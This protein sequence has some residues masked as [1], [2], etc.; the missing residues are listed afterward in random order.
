MFY[1]SVIIP[2]YNAAQYITGCVDSILNQTLENVEVIVVNDCSTDNSMEVCRAKYGDNPRVQLIDQEKNGGPAA[3]RNRGIE[4]ARGEYIAF[5]DSDDAMLPD[6]LKSMYTT[7]KLMNADVL[8]AMG[9]VYPIIEDMPDDL[10]ELTEDQMLKVRA[11]V[12]SP[13]DK[14]TL[15]DNDFG[16][17]LDNW[18]G[19]HYMW[20]IWNKL[21]KK[22]FLKEKNLSFNHMRLAEDQIFCFGAMFKADRYVV[23]PGSWYIYRLSNESLSRGKRNMSMLERGLRSQFQA[24]KA[25]ENELKDIP[26]F[27]EHKEDGE[28][29]IDFILDGLESSFVS[30]CYKAVGRDAVLHDESINKIFEEYYGD[31]ADFAKYLFCQDHDRFMDCDDDRDKYT[32]I[33]FWAQQK[34]VVNKKYKP[35]H[36]YVKSDDFKRVEPYDAGIYLERYERVRRNHPCF[37]FEL[38]ENVNE[39][40][41][42]KSVE[43]V[44]E[45]FPWMRYAAVVDLDWTYY[46][47]NEKVFLAEDDLPIVI[48][49]GSAPVRPGY[50][51]ANFH[52]FAIAYD[53]NYIMFTFSHTIADGKGMLSFSEAVMYRYLS[54]LYGD[55]E[56]PNVAKGKEGNGPVFNYKNIAFDYSLIDTSYSFDDFTKPALKIQKSDDEFIETGEYAEVKTDAEAFVKFAKEKGT[57]PAI[58]AYLLL[59]EMFQRLFHD[60]EKHVSA[61]MMVDTRKLFDA[62]FSMKNCVYEARIG[63]PG[64][65]LGKD[66]FTENAQEARAMM[67]A[68]TKDAY[69]VVNGMFQSFKIKNI[70]TFVF[71]YAARSGLNAYSDVLKQFTIREGGIA[72]VDMIEFNGEFIL[73][74]IF[75]KMSEFYAKKFIEIMEDY[76]LSASLYTAMTLPEEV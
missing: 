26:Y 47:K 46:Y 1:V 76:G 66:N 45:Y 2:L 49:K 22:S 61:N 38:K 69:S 5:A 24:V 60:N 75:N 62:E 39:D 10:M 18:I 8:H 42:K 53:E 50:E 37:T 56:A 32:S 3:A 64:K 30:V 27:V 72:K 48:K 9:V 12:V 16:K 51:S 63:I 7:A 14:V 13:I 19:Y 70:Q 23:L 52:G 44:L 68:Q 57:T 31:K 67:K 25:M 55:R 34:E 6:A 73:S 54:A 58:A 43:E 28:R 11:D 15:L 35:E 4:L 71:S 33:S 59:A 41:L 36:E 21:F 74:F 29:A 65:K 17:R 40:V 20:N